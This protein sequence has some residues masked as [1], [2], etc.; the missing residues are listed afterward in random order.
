MRLL[1]TDGLPCIGSHNYMNQQFFVKQSLGFNLFCGSSKCFTGTEFCLFV[2]NMGD[3]LL[4]QRINF[5]S[6]TTETCH[7]FY[8]KY[9][10]KC[11]E[12]NTYFCKGYMYLQCYRWKF[13]ATNNFK[14]SSNCEQHGWYDDIWSLLDCLEQNMDRKLRLILNKDLSMKK[15]CAKKSQQWA[16]N[17]RE[18]KSAC[19][20]QQTVRRS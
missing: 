5:L 6:E 11:V 2:S 4:E 18:K 8:I 20:F 9:Y 17:W 19:I 10:I 15:V 14:N 3:E 13:W 16:K 1:S 7:W 12:Q